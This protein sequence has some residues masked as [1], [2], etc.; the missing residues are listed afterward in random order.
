M[1]MTNAQKF[2]LIGFTHFTIATAFV[3]VGTATRH[4]AYLAAAPAFIAV[5]I[6]FIVRSRS[7][8]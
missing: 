3:I 1:H 4:W 5:G 2:Q 7:A 8:D 6:V